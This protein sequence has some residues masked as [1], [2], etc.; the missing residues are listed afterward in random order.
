MDDLKIRQYGDWYDLLRAGALLRQLLLDGQNLYDLVNQE[1][2]IKLE[3]E[4]ARS[5]TVPMKNGY[6]FH[7][8]MPNPGE[9]NRIVDVDDFRRTP[10]V[11]FNENINY[12]VRDII[13]YA[14]NVNGGVH[15]SQRARDDTQERVKK[16]YEIFT[17]TD[18][19]FQSQALSQICSV[20]IRA[21]SP[22][23]VKIKGKISARDKRP[24]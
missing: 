10:L 20:V 3:F 18:Y 14:A 16:L 7:N 22:L 4:V 8:V 5:N 2:D 6:S 1:Y 11:I 15:A 21:L 19:D 13:D 9:S 12:T 24:L 17:R 23:E